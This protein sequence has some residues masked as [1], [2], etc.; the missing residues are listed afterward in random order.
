MLSKYTWIIKLDMTTTHLIANGGSNGTLLLL[1]M[2]D[3]VRTLIFHQISV[4]YRAM[5]Y[6]GEKEMGGVF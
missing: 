5:V 6:R 1:I 3:E 4:K 2:N